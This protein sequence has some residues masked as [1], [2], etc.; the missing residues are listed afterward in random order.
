[1]LTDLLYLEDSNENENPAPVILLGTVTGR[2]SD[3]LTLRMD[4][5]TDAMTKEYRQILTGRSLPVGAR[6]AVMKVS[7]SYV[8]LGQVANPETAQ[9][10]TDL[11]SGATTADAVSK[12]NEILSALR[13][14]GIFLNDE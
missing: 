11:A 9:N 8:V 13:T 7:G 5:E 2:S 12:I 10:P 1:M 14:L 3:G 4:G 6:V